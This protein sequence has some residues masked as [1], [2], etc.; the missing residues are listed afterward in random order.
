MY[1]LSVILRI[2][3]TNKPCCILANPKPQATAVL[4][5]SARAGRA[6]LPRTFRAES[7]MGHWGLALF[8]VSERNFGGLHN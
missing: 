5:P 7:G 2:L 4:K 1:I 8:K 6:R 3:L